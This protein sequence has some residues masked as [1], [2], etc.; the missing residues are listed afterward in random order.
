MGVNLFSVNCNS[1]PGSNK[2]KSVKQCGI[3]P[4]TAANS[5]AK[6]CRMMNFN[7]KS[8]ANLPNSK[9]EARLV[10]EVRSKLNTLGLYKYQHTKVITT[11]LLPNLAGTLTNV[12]KC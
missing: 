2:R 9:D 6:S 12:E 7:T 5:A 4:D 3:D 10:L 8:D 1:L 11:T